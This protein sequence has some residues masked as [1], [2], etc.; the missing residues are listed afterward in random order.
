MDTIGQP[1]QTFSLRDLL[2]STLI[3]TVDADTATSQRFFN[4]MCEIAFEEYNPHTNQANNL[5]TLAFNYSTNDGSL[6]T[7]KVPILSLV[8][9]PLLQVQEADFSFDVQ[10]MGI[11]EETEEETLSLTENTRNE[12]RL[13]TNEPAQLIVALQPMSV[14]RSE[15][16]ASSGIFLPNMRVNIQLNQADM[17]GGLSRMLNVVN[18]I[19]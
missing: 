17:P 4:N 3:A 9:L 11:S 7:L 12:D 6:H 5:R 16:V 2:S 19:D 15:D 10:I 18:N 13:Q 14:N 8:P 1:Y